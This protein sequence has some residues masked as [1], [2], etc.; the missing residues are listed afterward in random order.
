MD[1]QETNQVTPV[2]IERTAKK[3]KLLWL[4]GIVYIL[5]GLIVMRIGYSG[6]P[7]MPVIVV[8][9]VIVAVGLVLY[10]YAKIAAWWY[11]G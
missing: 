7:D 9:G 6:Q 11:H 4:I 3:W 5:V 10:V 2:T 8:G 1:G